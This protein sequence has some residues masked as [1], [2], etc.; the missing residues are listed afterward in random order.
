MIPVSAQDNSSPNSAMCFGN[1][2]ASTKTV[3]MTW[4]VA[5][6]TTLHTTSFV[7]QV[8]T[9]TKEAS[10]ESVNV[11]VTFTKKPSATSIIVTT[12]V[13]EKANTTTAEIYITETVPASALPASTDCGYTTVAPRGQRYMDDDL[14]KSPGIIYW[15][16][17]PNRW[18]ADIRIAFE[19]IDTFW[20]Q[21]NA[22][23]GSLRIGPNGPFQNLEWEAKVKEKDP[24]QWLHVGERQCK[25][26]MTKSIKREVLVDYLDM[27]SYMEDD[28]SIE[29]NRCH[30]L[31]CRMNTAL[32][33]CNDR[34]ERV[35]TT[36]IDF[37]RLSNGLLA[38]C[39]RDKGPQR[40]GY[41]Y[42]PIDH[43]AHGTRIVMSYANCDDSPSKS[44]FSY[45]DQQ[46][47]WCC[48]D[49]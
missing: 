4:T 32:W 35:T 42:F 6:T 22:Q 11:T 30:R 46:L 12:T 15:G 10:T 40:S 31:G 19:S 1:A 36:L 49:N 44:P 9:L 27:M 34:K 5:V 41:Q 21:I 24:G 48:Q 14:Y 8:L 25:H 17:V 13:T 16:T 26:N 47:P 7:P 28:W 29:P 39:M 43:P 45:E 20:W 37:L 23:S 33:W 3:L 38:K 18:N 2:T